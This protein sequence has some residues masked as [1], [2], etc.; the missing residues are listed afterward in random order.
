MVR[1]RVLGAV[2]DITRRLP[3]FSSLLLE[4]T[5]ELM[6][7]LQSKTDQTINDLKKQLRDLGKRYRGWSDPR[8]RL[9]RHEARAS[10]AS[11]KCL[12]SSVER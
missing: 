7:R 6:V 9:M 12:C 5:Q 10:M 8:L 3:G 2:A 1:R 4:Q 11:I